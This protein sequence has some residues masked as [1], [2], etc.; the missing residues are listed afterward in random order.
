MVVVVLVFRRAMYGR[1]G[2]VFVRDCCRW[3][4][5]LVVDMLV[6]VAVVAVLCRTIVAVRC[7]W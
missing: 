4:Y 3:W 6:V 7:C 5:R 1:G 2:G